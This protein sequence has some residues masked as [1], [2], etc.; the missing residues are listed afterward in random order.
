MILKHIEEDIRAARP[1]TGMKGWVGSLLGHSG[2][3]VSVAVLFGTHNWDSSRLVLRLLEDFGLAR[4]VALVPS[5]DQPSGHGLPDEPVLA[6]PDEVADRVT[7]SQL[8]GMC[9]A[10]TNYIVART[11]TSSPTVLKYLPYGGLSEVRYL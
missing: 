1:A 10:L 6:I 3:C 2:Q 8:Y 4:P 7:I 9:D 11:R 5:E